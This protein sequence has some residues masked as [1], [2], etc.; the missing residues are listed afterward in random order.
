MDPF[1]R[2]ALGVTR[3]LPPYRASWWL[4]R[5]IAVAYQRLRRR[6]IE[7]VDVNVLGFQMTLDVRDYSDECLLFAP[8]VCDHVELDYVR[9]RLRPGDTFL[10]IGSHQGIYS[11]VASR[12]VGETGRVLAFEANSSTY[13]RLKRNLEENGALNVLALHVGVSNRSERRRLGINPTNTGG[14]SFV[15]SGRTCGELV[16]CR[17]LLDL[18]DEHLVSTVRVAKLDIEG[19]EHA[20]LAALLA[21][22]AEG[23][24]PQ[25]AILE[26]NE[27]IGEEGARARE[28]LVLNGYREVWRGELNVILER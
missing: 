4:A 19:M 23:R 6:H 3:R 2:V 26:V 8:Q 20:V 15:V 25:S 13:A 22:A 24:W 21:G 17:P 5:R 18:L 7:P 27:S 10:D 9:S 11:L 16:D 12:C 28:L 1:L 14:S